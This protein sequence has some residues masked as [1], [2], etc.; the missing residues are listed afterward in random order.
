MIIKKMT[1]SFGVLNNAGL[2]LSQG[3]NIIN[4]PNE[5]GKSTWGAFIKAM[6]YGI[7]TS[8]RE[9][10]GEKPDKV[11]YAPW[12]GAP[13]SGTMEIEYEGRDVTLSRRGRESAPLRDFSAVITGT[14]DAVKI[15]AGAVGETLLG[16]PAEVFERSAYIKQGKV[17]VG[18]SPQLEKRISAIVQTGDESSSYSEAE[19]KLRAAMRKRRH[20]KSGR[21]PEIENEGRLVREKL[22]AIG[23][24]R[25]RLEQLKVAK[26]QALERRDAL[27]AQV[28]ESRK[29]QRRDSLEQ[30]TQSRNAL[31]QLE[32]EFEQKREI[33]AAAER[34]LS[35]GRF[36][37]QQPEQC[38]R[39]VEET[40]KKY[41]ELT[42]KA[43]KGGNFKVQLGIILAL[44]I[45]AAALG[46]LAAGGMVG[47][48]SAL[49]YL[50]TVISAALAAVLGFRL[51][52]AKK[53]QSSLNAQAA[54]LLEAFECRNT[55][56]LLSE[57]SQHEI[58]YSEYQKARQELSNCGKQFDNA[59]QEQTKQ[60]EILLKDLDFAG[61]D[62]KSAVLTARLEEAELN[63]RRI[64]EE[65]AACE[66]RQSALG[67]ARELTERLHEL[68]GEHEKLSLEYDALLLAADTLREAGEEIQARMTPRLSQLTA[69]LFAKMTGDKYDAIALDKELKALA[70]LSGDSVSRE[71]AF[72][73]VGAVDQLYLA[74]RL[75]IC[76]LALP[77]DKP[78]PLVL[79]DVLVNFDDQ[80][81]TLALEL[82]RSLA[83]QRQI[84]LFT[85]HGREGDLMKKY[86]D[87]RIINA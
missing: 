1:A 44:I 3:L 50:P 9:K 58:A 19:E 11:K 28:A 34:R 84:I 31:R 21:L 38:R 64:R 35:A 14:A 71:A 13:M 41:R 82:L 80:R 48:G 29:E 49:Y 2:E 32:S 78:C 86:S 33:A 81:C 17:P 25:Q 30:L 59:R 23:G 26:A 22:D 37:A 66:G 61:G 18:A 73:S 85:C 51:S 53:K 27:T 76:S 6:L 43:E 42:E 52:G 83:Q 56:E 67:G 20:N 68:Q 57:L 54:Q 8:A 4:A 74:V 69:E 72:L 15:P 12:S 62:G 87:V 63:L 79:D 75:A 5:S 55:E 60:D 24:E 77:E 16:I 7:D 40:I 65:A 39:Q 36:S 46:V 10:G 47:D 70:R 45:I